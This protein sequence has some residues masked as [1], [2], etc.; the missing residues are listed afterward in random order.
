MLGEGWPSF[1]LAQ[2][3]LAKQTRT[4]FHKD[5]FSGPILAQKTHIQIAFKTPNFLKAN[6]SGENVTFHEPIASRLFLIHTLAHGIPASNLSCLQ[7][8]WSL[9]TTGGIY[10]QIPRNCFVGA[11]HRFL[12]SK[13]INSKKGELCLIIS[14]PL[15]LSTTIYQLQPFISCY[16]TGFF[17]KPCQG[18]GLLWCPFYRWGNWG[19][20][21]SHVTQ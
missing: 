9:P 14:L 11:L 17:P 4:Y 13:I 21:R 2:P 18:E 6:N 19:S 8:W 1:Q 10:S 3:N 12:L 15:T 20:G 5:C 16:L 7:P